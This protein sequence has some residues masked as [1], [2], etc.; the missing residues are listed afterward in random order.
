[1]KRITSTLPR[2]RPSLV[3][4]VVTGELVPRAVYEASVVSLLSYVQMETQRIY[5]ESREQLIQEI[6]DAERIGSANSFGR[7]Q[8]YTSNYKQLP[9]HILA[10]SRVNELVLHKLISETASYVRNPNPLKQEPSFGPKVNLGAVNKQ[11][12]SLSLVN[13]TLSLLWKCWDR[14][15]L[16]EFTIP[17]YFLKREIIKWCL[18]TV[19]MGK[20]GIVFYFAYQETPIP[21]TNKGVRAGLDLGRVEPYTLVVEDNNEYHT[22][23]AGSRVK[24]LEEKRNRLLAEK[25]HITTKLHTY[26]QLGIMGD[27]FD[28]LKREVKRT[29]NKASRLGVELAH[30]MSNEITRKLSQHHTHELVVEDLTWV[31]GPKYGGR[32]N[33]SIQQEKIT[34]SLARKG[35]RVRKTS[36][37]NTSNNCYKC[38]VKLVHN[39]RKRTVHCIECKTILDRD[40]SAALNILQRKSYLI[41]LVPA[42]HGSNGLLPKQVVLTTT[43]QEQEIKPQPKT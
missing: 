34:H 16:F 18:P 32:W 21:R 11:M 19:Q 17:D 33:H 8:G 38:G 36:P 22:Y 43:Q 1:M 13:N 24:G 37:R 30:Q 40:Y 31:T 41:S 27:K 5:S 20:E 6:T 2:I 7:K 4:D 28:V 25:K 3:V 12:A 29:A 15:F 35:V 9:T 26:T 23:T 10:K 14:E 39:T 42:T